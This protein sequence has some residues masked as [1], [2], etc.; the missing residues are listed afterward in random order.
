MNESI[1]PLF[2]DRYKEFSVKNPV[3]AIH[4]MGLFTIS[5]DYTQEAIAKFNSKKMTNFLIGHECMANG[6]LPF[7]KQNYLET[8]SKVLSLPKELLT[9]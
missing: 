7:S 1:Y 8:F 4:N 2:M 5:R 3:R 9:I 6:L